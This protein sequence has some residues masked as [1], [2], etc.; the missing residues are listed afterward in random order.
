MP[1]LQCCGASHPVVKAQG[2]CQLPRCSDVSTHSRPG[3]AE[4]VFFRI[5]FALSVY[6][7]QRVGLTG[8]DA[9]QSGPASG[10]LGR[11]VVPSLF[12]GWHAGTYACM[13]AYGTGLG[14]TAGGM[15]IFHSFGVLG[16]W[17]LVAS[18]F[19]Y[20][21]LSLLVWSGHVNLRCS[22]HAFGILS[23]VVLVII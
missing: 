12:Y 22:C 20:H 13:R 23:V 8:V 19:D 9:T 6:L 15:N 1:E 7:L 10:R 4:L 21:W 11:V 18:M 5:K 2:L 16:W 17:R 14:P 3:S